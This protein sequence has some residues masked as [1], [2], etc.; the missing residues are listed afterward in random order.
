MQWPKFF[1]LI[2]IPF[3]AFDAIIKISILCRENID[4]TVRLV[5]SYNG[6]SIG[7]VRE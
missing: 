5:V 3:V 7:T 2:R 6:L 1:I 4:M